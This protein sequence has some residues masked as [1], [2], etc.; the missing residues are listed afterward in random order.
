DII[1]KLPQDIFHQVLSLLD[2]KD[3]VRT[4][5]VSK[6][7][8]TLWNSIPTLNFN[9]TDFRTLK[10]F[11][12]FVNYVLSLR[13]NDCNVHTIRYHREG[14]TDKSLMNKVI[15][16]AVTHSVRYLKV[17]ASDFPPFTPSRKFFKCQSLQNLALR[18]FRDVWFPVE[19]SLF[20]SLTI[21]NFK[22][23]TIV[24]NKNIRNYNPDECFDPFL[25][26]V[27]LKFLCLQDCLFSGGKTLKLTL[28]KVVNLTIVRLIYES[29]NSTNNGEAKVELF[30]PKMTA[31][32]FSSSSR[33]LCF[34]K[35]DIS[36]LE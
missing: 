31:F 30:A 8:E 35:M 25:G 18:N 33:A 20:N 14:S 5:F 23:C 3:A 28:P 7:W 15:N 24:H 2:T 6:K 27:N 17:S 34:S 26:C 10:S 13:D 16:Y 21:L 19:A 11:K 36:S 1:S 12:K 29:N 32:N 22:E 9:S 4:S